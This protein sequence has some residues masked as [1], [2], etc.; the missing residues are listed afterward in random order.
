VQ[1]APDPTQPEAPLGGPETPPERG[2]TP[3]PDAPDAATMAPELRPVPALPWNTRGFHP[4]AGIMALI[5]PGL[6]HFVL[7]MPR[8]ARLI[9]LGVLGLFFTGLLI[10]GLDAV[11]SHLDRWWFYAQVMTGPIAF[12][13]DAVHIHL[14][15]EGQ[16]VQGLGRMNELGTLSCAMAGFMNLVAVLDAMFP[17]L[18]RRDEGARL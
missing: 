11:D 7:G 8:R 12:I 17:P 3:A 16:I 14:R 9:M 4:M 6:G 10:G 1:A 18:R 2:Q 15:H 5:L 13:T